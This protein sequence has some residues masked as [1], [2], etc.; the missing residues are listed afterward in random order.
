MA[1]PCL[2]CNTPT[3]HAQARVMA[4]EGLW[5]ERVAILACP[6]CNAFQLTKAGSEKVQRLSNGYLA[7]IGPAAKLPAPKAEITKVLSD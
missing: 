3:R 1:K 5:V 7:M 4:I 2:K 6:E